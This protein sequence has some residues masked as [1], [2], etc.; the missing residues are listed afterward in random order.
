MK[1]GNK[2]YYSLNKK[3][4]SNS[5][6]N[7][8]KKK[9]KISKRILGYDLHN[10]LNKKKI[11][12]N[13]INKKYFFETSNNLNNFDN[14]E[15]LIIRDING[16]GQ[17]NI[18]IKKK[19]DINYK[20]DDNIIYTKLMLNPHLIEGYKYHFRVYYILRNSKEIYYYKYFRV[21]GCKEHF[22]L[23]NLNENNIISSRPN[24][25][26][27]E[28]YFPNN[29]Y[30]NEEVNIINKQIIEIG[31]E[32]INLVRLKNKSSLDWFQILG[33]DFMINDKMEIKIAEINNRQ[34]AFIID[35]NNTNDKYYHNDLIKN[36][37]NLLEYDIT[38]NDN[39]IKISSD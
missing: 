22:N 23:E 21:F 12:D 8:I 28:N 30:T 25:R 20:N 38:K 1:I 16:L 36:I 33:G 19:K 27:K 9:R 24:S 10:I 37:N 7:Y 15:Y 32:I 39:L 34:V 4:I 18:F 31:K 17:K 5:F 6:Y 29:N 3:F 14:E 2:Y 26:L 35:N 11:Y 13:F